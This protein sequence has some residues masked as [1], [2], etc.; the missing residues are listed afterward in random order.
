MNLDFSCQGFSDTLP[1]VRADRLLGIL[2]LLQRRERAT[3]GDLARRLEVSTRTIYRDVEA[4]GTAGVPIYTEQG[5]NGGIRL[6][7]GYRTDLT[8][9]NL[10]EAQLLPLIG[11]SGILAEIGVGPSLQRTEEKVL[12]ALGADHQERAELSRRRIHVDLSRWWETAE[13]VPH[14]PS[15]AE[16]ALSGRRLRIRCRRGDGKVV[17]RTL[18]PL[19]LVVQ[20]GIWY[21][22]GRNRGSERIYRVSRIQGAEVLDETFELPDDFDLSAFWAGR[23]E[24][25]HMTREAYR[26]LARVRPRALRALQSSGAREAPAEP[27][28]DGWRT[29][30]LS[31]GTRG[32]AFE[33]LLGLGPDVVV[34]EPE[35]LRDRIAEAVRRMGV[36]Y[37]GSTG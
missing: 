3:A 24:E 14:L 7:G 16:A 37:E 31:F 11:L 6:L 19:G 18:D 34:L 2:L 25:F 4:L 29:V 26:V 35:E 21:V 22:V 32:I 13:A 27:D 1:S 33:R 20:G 8:G 5:R 17:R 36:L 23:K 10:G 12:A 28:P 9:L 30:E 15:V